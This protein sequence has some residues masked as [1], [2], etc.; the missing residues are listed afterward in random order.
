MT[1]EQKTRLQARGELG[2]IRADIQGLAESLAQ[3]PLWRPAAGLRDA[4]G[5]AMVMLDR[6]AE[7]FDRRLVVT[8]VGPCGSGKSTLLNALA[9]DD[10]LSPAGHRRP[11]TK[12]VVAF[13]RQA[14]DAAQLVE[15]IG[16]DKIRVRTSTAAQALEN[17]ILIDT[18]DTDSTHQAQ[19]IPIVHKAI[20]L[21]D[22]L[23]CVFDGENPKRRDHTDFLTEY[24]GLF[25][26][27]SLVVAVNK[28]DRLAESELSDIIMPD[29]AAYIRRA[30]SI[31]PAAIICVSARSHLK[32]PDWDP[33]T[34]PKHDLDQFDQLHELIRDTFNRSGV[35]IDRRLENARSIRQYIQQAVRDEAG[36]A[37]DHLQAAIDQMAAG[38][39]AAMRQAVSSF[40]SADDT[41]MPGIHIRLYQQLAQRWLGPVGWL[42]AVWTRILVFGA[43]IT[44]LMRFGNPIR[45]LAGAVSAV[46]HYA[47]TKKATDAADRGPGAS[48]ALLRYESALARAW[49]DIAERLIQAGFVPSVR[50]AHRAPGHGAE[51]ERQLSQ[52]W[53]D[54]LNEELSQ[55]AQRLSGGL[56][57][58]IFNL[59]VLGILGYVG[60][61]TAVNFFSGNILAS[62]F[63]LHAFWTIVLVL[64][65]SFFLL[66][67]VIRLAAGKQRMVE[68]V[69]ARVRQSV[70]RQTR[71]ADSPVWQQ[72]TI[73]IGLR[74]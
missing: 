20:T 56:L 18:P 57:Q 4:C 3:T 38:E 13:C 15:Q 64:F 28:S 14:A 35:S 12:G 21:S 31:D 49:P 36:N 24:V 11:T 40:R 51:I 63:F 32:D 1:V 41:L 42:V 26:G 69:F 43:G 73:V 50:E 23:I 22:V 62:S 44:A 9:G 60:W 19:H 6:L 30:W 52:I 46:R 45:Q 29:F 17:L 27:A 33:E 71:L 59:P 67:A 8:L 39:A 53:A 34:A 61:L 55:T 25:N 72:A 10:H 47:D 54:A 48:V 68:G 5:E 2:T 65:L 58:L 74:N 37:G 16:R 7:R 66:Q 70:D